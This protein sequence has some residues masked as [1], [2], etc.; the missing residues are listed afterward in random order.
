MS[1]T[2]LIR[3]VQTFRKSSVVFNGLALE[4]VL[5]CSTG[6]KTM[7]ELVLLTGSTNGALTHAIRSVMPYANSASAEIIRP[8]LHLLMRKKIKGAR[9]YRYKLT[10]AGRELLQGVSAA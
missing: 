9:G 7:A 6:D 4:V 2:D 5:H 8:T 1:S 10:R 3:I